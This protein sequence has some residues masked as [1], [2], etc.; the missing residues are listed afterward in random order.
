MTYLVFG[1]IILAVVRC[2]SFGIYTIRRG[3]ISGGVVTMLL[4]IL[5]VLAGLAVLY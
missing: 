4:G 1:V 2:L 3:N 5:S